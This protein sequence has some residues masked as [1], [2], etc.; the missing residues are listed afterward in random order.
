[1]DSMDLIRMMTS[2]IRH[3][4]VNIQEVKVLHKPHPHAQQKDCF[5]N[6][7]RAMGSGDDDKYVLGYLLFNAGDSEI[8]I[9]HAWVKQHGQYFDVTLDPK[10]QKYISLVEID[11]ETLND[12]A[13]EE[14][15]APDL[16]S[17][18]RFL[19]KK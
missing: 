16:Y 11:I 8:P 2:N 19:G 14:G 15:H 10:D 4:D 18:N 12:Y 13:S 7:F 3:L 17:L 9:E 6:S 1:M 5:N